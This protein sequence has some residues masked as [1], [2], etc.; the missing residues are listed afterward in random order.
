MFSDG[1]TIYLSLNFGKF[2]PL[3]H[4]YFLIRKYLYTFSKLEWLLVAKDEI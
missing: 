3:K 1:H 4:L 2:V